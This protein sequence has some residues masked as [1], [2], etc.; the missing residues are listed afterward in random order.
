MDVT[1]LRSCAL[2]FRSDF[3]TL[4]K[5]DPFRSVTI[6]AA[7]QK[8]YRTFLLQKDEIA[9]ISGHGYQANRKTSVEA[10]EWLEWLNSQT[11]GNIQHGRNGKEYKVGKYFVD[12]FNPFSNTAYEYNGSA[13]HGCPCCTEPEDLVPFSRITMAQACQLREEKVHYLK[14]RG[15]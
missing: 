5:I 12:G 10:T 11:S 6:A 13:F 3:I 4:C 2:K 8:Y 1:V 9:V 7:C 14:A 15:V